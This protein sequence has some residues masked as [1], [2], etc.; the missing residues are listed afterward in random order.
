[1]LREVTVSMPFFDLPLLQE[2][3]VSQQIEHA[4]DVVSPF[5]RMVFCRI[6]MGFFSSHSLLC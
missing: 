1:M 6:R 3:L 4:A 2:V 5:S